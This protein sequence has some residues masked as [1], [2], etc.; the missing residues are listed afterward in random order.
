MTAGIL[1]AF[2]GMLIVLEVSYLY[3]ISDG[4]EI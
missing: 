2:N 1:N 4:K 3:S